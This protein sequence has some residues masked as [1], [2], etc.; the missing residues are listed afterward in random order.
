MDAVVSG[1]EIME[2]TLGEWSQITTL[3]KKKKKES[4]ILDSRMDS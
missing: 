3:K 4:W 1:V 2:R